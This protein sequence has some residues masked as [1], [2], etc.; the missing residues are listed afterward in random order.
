MCVPSCYASST[1][2][3]LFYFHFRFFPHFKVCVWCEAV[4]SSLPHFLVTLFLFLLIIQLYSEVDVKL[5]FKEVTSK[6]LRRCIVEV[7]ICFFN[8]KMSS[9]YLFFSLSLLNHLLY[10][11][12]KWEIFCVYGCEQMLCRTP[13]SFSSFDGRALCMYKH[14]NRLL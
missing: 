12:S 8:Q 9:N 10:V 4:Q 3:S 5:V 7:W 14:C 13:F 1:S 2:N 6:Y 11:S